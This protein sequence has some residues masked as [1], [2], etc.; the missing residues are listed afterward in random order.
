MVLPIRAESTRVIVR[1][2]VHVR[3]ILSNSI[4][5]NGLIG[6]RTEPLLF[7][8]AD[9]QFPYNK[10]TCCGF[11]AFANIPGAQLV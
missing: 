10:F 4:R 1:F 7:S 9:Y 3:L 2:R 11:P 8:T 5:F 6:S